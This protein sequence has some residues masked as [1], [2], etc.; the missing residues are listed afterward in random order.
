[1]HIYTYM[2]MH[3]YTYINSI[4]IHINTCIYI[5]ASERRGLDRRLDLGT[6]MNMKEY[7]IMHLRPYMCRNIYVYVHTDQYI[8]LTHMHK[9]IYERIFICKCVCMN[10]YAWMYEYEYH[11]HCAVA[12]P[13]IHNRFSVQ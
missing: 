11:I 7:M 3:I 4:Y 1:M 9:S 2:Y 5:P 10:I 8:F 12:L 13:H 6:P